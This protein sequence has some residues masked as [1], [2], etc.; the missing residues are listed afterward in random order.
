MK[1]NEKHLQSKE[2]IFGGRYWNQKE[3]NIK[4]DLINCMKK[5]TQELKED[6]MVNVHQDL[7][8]A[9]LKK[10]RKW[11]TLGQDGVYRF[12]LKHSHP[13]TTDCLNK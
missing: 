5:E 3:D 4:A 2:D 11:K 13:T 12:W 9:T 1:R 6:P 8:R 10:V 7:L